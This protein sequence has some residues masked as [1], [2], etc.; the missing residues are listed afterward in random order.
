VAGAS[1][2]QIPK[3]WADFFTMMLLCPGAFQWAKQFVTSPALEHLARNSSVL[4]PFSFLELFQMQVSFYA[5]T[6]YQ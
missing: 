3:A 2:V 4:V 1:S 6:I 5:P